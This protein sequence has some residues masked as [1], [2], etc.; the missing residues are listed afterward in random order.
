VC[1]YPN[2]LRVIKSKRLRWTG[3]TA[4]IGQKIKAYMVLV[5]KPEERKPLGKPRLSCEDNI[6]TDRREIGWGI[7]D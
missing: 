1:F 7:M 4:S 3:N 2:I 6:K 5:E